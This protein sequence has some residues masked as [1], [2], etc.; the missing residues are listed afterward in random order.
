MPTPGRT[1]DPHPLRS[2]AS[3]PLTVVTALLDLGRGSEHNSLAPDQR[4]TFSEYRAHFARL[5]AVN[6]PMVIYTSSDLEPFIWR[7]RRPFNTRI[8]RLTLASLEQDFTGFEAVARIRGNS[9]WRNQA[10]WLPGSPQAALA[11]YNPLVMSK[12]A[13]LAATAADDPFQSEHWVWLDAGIARTCA[14]VLANDTWP[15]QLS[16]LLQSLQNRL[17]TLAYPYLQGTE[18]HGFARSAMAHWANTD[19]VR[20]VT[21]GGL[22]GGSRS[23]IDAAGERYQQTLDATLAAGYMGTEESV[24]T[25]VAHRHPAL[26][27]REMLAED[28][29]VAPFL[30]QLVDTAAQAPAS[31]QSS[32]RTAPRPPAPLLP[33]YHRHSAFT[34]SRSTHPV[35]LPLCCNPG[36][37]SCMRYRH[38]NCT[39]STTA[40]TR[41]VSPKI[42]GLANATAP[43]T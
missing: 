43:C 29:L 24:L 3:P 40:P 34:S 23:A 35:S 25:I 38:C 33:R 21:R 36:T 32:T 22:F 2:S 26:F 19:H 4:R 42:F 5:L 10:P 1:A 37:G 8:R 18:I 6:L 14:S 9:A 39:L 27:H 7:H 16:M 12:P 28:G 15:A 20:W 41:S 17:L 11:H 13:L 30:Q 31:F